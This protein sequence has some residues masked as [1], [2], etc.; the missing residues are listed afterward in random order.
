MEPHLSDQPSGPQQA[1]NQASQA[2]HSSARMSFATLTVS[3]FSNPSYLNQNIF[4]CGSTRPNDDPR[5]EAYLTVIRTTYL[6]HYCKHW[7][8]L[9]KHAEERFVYEMNTLAQAYHPR[10]GRQ[11]VTPFHGL[12][13]WLNGWARWLA[14][15]PD[16]PMARPAVNGKRGI[17]S[18]C[19]VEV[20]GRHKDTEAMRALKKAVRW[21]SRTT[22]QKE[23]WQSKV[24]EMEKSVKAE[25][26]DRSQQDFKAVEEALGL[27]E[28]HGHSS[29]PR[30]GR[31]VEGDK[32]D[33]LDDDPMALEDG[34]WKE[35]QDGVSRGWPASEVV[36]FGP[37]SGGSKEE[38]VE[39]EGADGP[40]T[41]ELME[42]QNDAACTREDPLYPGLENVDDGHRTGTSPSSRVTEERASRSLMQEARFRGPSRFTNSHENTSRGSTGVQT[43]LHELS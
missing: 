22:I 23:L 25:W 28:E 30:G 34:L 35:N 10:F 31:L 5:V 6:L 40:V 15:T 41:D 7:I 1:E 13:R 19:G 21:D 29:P 2:A 27:G 14:E 3:I 8:G 17:M 16:R 38:E 42:E 39:M 18:L 43:W 20:H 32:T 24:A 12:E 11:A 37:P 36:D 9:R 26:E 33:L 4:T